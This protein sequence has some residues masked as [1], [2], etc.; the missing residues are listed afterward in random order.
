MNDEDLAR[1]YIRNISTYQKSGGTI[2]AE[3]FANMTKQFES[4][5]K[6]NCE[7]P[8][9]RGKGVWYKN[10]DCYNPPKKSNG[11]TK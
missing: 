10:C 7:C 5:Y 11:A 9:K 3:D 2:K 4:H 8:T 1:N 6:D